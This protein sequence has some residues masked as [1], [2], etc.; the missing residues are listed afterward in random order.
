MPLSELL[1][2][3]KGLAKFLNR[4]LET[5]IASEDVLTSADDL[6]NEIQGAYDKNESIYGM[7]KSEEN[8]LTAFEKE[9]G[10]KDEEIIGAE[11]NKTKKKKMK[12]EE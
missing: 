3:Q 2:D 8:I 5:R 4:A 7:Q 12:M 11:E 10:Q 1:A 6:F 9:E